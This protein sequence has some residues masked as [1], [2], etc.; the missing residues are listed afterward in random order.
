MKLHKSSRVYKICSCTIFA[1]GPV[2]G[3]DG[4]G[5]LVTKPSRFTLLS[6]EDGRVL[7]ALCLNEERIKADADIVRQGDVP[8]SAFVL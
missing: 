8:H 5:P 2:G 4:R 7:D 6:D 3:M 1:N